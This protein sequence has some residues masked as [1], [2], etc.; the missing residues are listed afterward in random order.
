MKFSPDLIKDSDKLFKLHTG[1]PSYQVFK[2]IFEKIKAKAS[3]LR[4]LR[5]EKSTSKANMNKPGRGSIID[6]EHKFLLTMMKLKL[7]LT[8]EDLAFRFGI[9]VS[10][11]SRIVRTWFCFLGKEL[12]SLIYFPTAEENLRY[13]PS[14]F[15]KDDKVRVIIDCTEIGIEKPSL[16]KAQAQTYSN[17]KS[18]NTCKVLIGCTP[19]GYPCFV[20][21]AYG[22]KASDRFIVENSGFLDTI[23]DGDTVMADKGFDI[24]DLL[25][26]KQSKLI[27]PP[28]KRKSEKRFTKCKAKLTSQIAKARIHV[29]RCIGRLKNFLLLKTTI[30]IT[31]KDILSDIFVICAAVTC[32]QPPLV[33]L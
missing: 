11:C 28:F 19:A 7:G 23:S 21:K 2:F 33:P 14:C 22:G 18:R 24:Q 25:L 9:S 12:K 26:A 8:Q 31:Q 29:E 20:S 17:Y 27:I 16:A 13:Y 10:T 6:D 30:P 3:R 5:G 32:L 1:F 4:Y 15:K